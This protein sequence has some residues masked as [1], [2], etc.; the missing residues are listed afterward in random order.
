MKVAGTFIAENPIDI[1]ALS[2]VGSTDDLNIRGSP[3]LDTFRTL[4]WARIENELATTWAFTI[5]SPVGY[6]LH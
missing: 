5:A 2:V 1:V 4:G 6:T 3:L